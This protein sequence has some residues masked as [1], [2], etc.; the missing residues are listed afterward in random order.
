MSPLVSDELFKLCF[1]VQQHRQHS[2]NG[3]RGIDGTM[4]SND[5]IDKAMPSN[6]TVSRQT[7][8]ATPVRVE[9]QPAVRG[10][11]RAAQMRNAAI[12]TPISPGA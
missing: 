3:I 6:V 7:G 11:E 2:T 9:P 5:C 4:P 10:D 1:G 8:I 12:P